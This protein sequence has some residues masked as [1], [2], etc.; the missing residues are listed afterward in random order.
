M[1]EE[2]L[3]IDLRARVEDDDD[4]LAL[5]LALANERTD[6]GG[7][8]VAHD[9]HR[10]RVLASVVRDHATKRRESTCDDAISRRR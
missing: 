5:A 2:S 8:V 10:A 6:D 9:G 4:A 7:A 3:R 1:D